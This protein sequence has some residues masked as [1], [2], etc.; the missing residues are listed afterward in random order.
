MHIIVPCELCMDHLN[1]MV[2]QCVRHLG[3]N[4]AATRIQQID[5]RVGPVAIK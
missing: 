1:K 5:K 3:A 4:R 2:K